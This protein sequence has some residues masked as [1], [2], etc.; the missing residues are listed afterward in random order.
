[1]ISMAPASDSQIYVLK[2]YGYDTSKGVTIA[3]ARLAFDI[4]N[5]EKEKKQ[6]VKPTGYPIDGL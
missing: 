5:K 2:K 4:I 6:E 3:E 1:M